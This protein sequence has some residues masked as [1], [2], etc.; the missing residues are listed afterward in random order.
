M[1][2]QSFRPGEPSSERSTARRTHLEM[3]WYQRVTSVSTNRDLEIVI[4]KL[5][6]NCPPVPI[7]PQSLLKPKRK[8]ITVPVLF[9]VLFAWL[10][11]VFTR[12][13]SHRNGESFRQAREE[14][15]VT[16]NEL[17]E[18]LPDRW[19]QT[20]P[21]NKW[22]IDAIRREERRQKEKSRRM[23]RNRKRKK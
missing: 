10:K 5:Q 13:P 14:V 16:S 17:D 12:L 21:E 3:Q 19:L 11:D 9:C 6:E 4:I 22:T 23:N 20:H 1:S 2:I 7:D 15:S 8:S 18:L